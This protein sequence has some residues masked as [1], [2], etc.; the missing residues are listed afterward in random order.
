MICAHCEEEFDSKSLA[1]RKAGGKINECPDCALESTIPYA[2]VASSDGK[3]GQI[4]ILKFSSKQDRENYIRFWRNNSG[5]NKSKS[6]QLGNHLST[7]PAV[8]F[9]TI[10]AFKPTNHKGKSNDY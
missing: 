1:K 3:M 9:E 8:S 5:I 10:Q 2:G 6:C 4:S 7:T